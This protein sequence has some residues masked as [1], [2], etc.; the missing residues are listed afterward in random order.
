MNMPKYDYG[1][2]A[3]STWIGSSPL[4]FLL[5]LLYIMCKRSKKSNNDHISTK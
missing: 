3:L 4:S 5:Y 1:S 2:D